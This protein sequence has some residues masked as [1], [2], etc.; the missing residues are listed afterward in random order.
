VSYLLDVIADM[1]YGVRDWFESKPAEQARLLK[2]LNLRHMC[3]V[4]LVCTVTGMMC[5][6][7]S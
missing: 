7:L 1:F 6:Q 4:V 3:M 5:C 2:P